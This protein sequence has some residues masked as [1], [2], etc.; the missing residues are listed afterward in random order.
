MS[1]IHLQVVAG[2]ANRIRALVSGICLA[3][4]YQFPLVIHWS[5][6]HACGAPFE[7]LFDPLCLPPF[8]KVISLPLLKAFPCLSSEDLEHVKK[9]WDKKLPLT[10]KSYGHFHTTDMVRWIRHLKSLQPTKQIL[11]LLQNRLPPFEP[12]RFIGVHIR[13]TDN[14]K[15]ILASPFSSFLTRL[16]KEDG[17]FIVATDD[18]DV[19][20]ELLDKFEGRVW[21]PSQI[22]NRNTVEGIQEAMIDF[23]A[24]SSCRRILGSMHSSFN[25]MA[26]LYGSC[27]LE[28]VS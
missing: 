25:E 15:A 12:D 28:R 3:E 16:E 14:E 6:D 10:L 19:R 23:L 26:A 17:F 8:V 7:A 20:A 21:F 9:V 1:E 24:L 2:L 4:D 22:V 13:R 27:T 18:L 5:L 11:Q